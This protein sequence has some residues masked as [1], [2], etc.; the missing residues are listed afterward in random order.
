MRAL[1]AFTIAVLG[2]GLVATACGGGSSSETPAQAKTKITTAYTDFFNPSAPFSQK[3]GLIENGPTMAACL[4]TQATNPLL[5]Q[6]GGAQVVDITLQGNGQAAVKFN[7]VG[8]GSPPST[9]TPAPF[10]GTAIK[11]NGTWKVTDQT[12]NML[13][14]LGGLHC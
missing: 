14:G 1:R 3:N 2:L 8:P 13:L 4:Q 10:A 7:L 9:L 6:L 12:F 11:Q 5:K